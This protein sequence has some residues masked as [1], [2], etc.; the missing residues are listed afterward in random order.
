M[1]VIRWTH[2]ALAA[3]E[4]ENPDA[5]SPCRAGASAAQSGRGP[6]GAPSKGNLGGR[7]REYHRGPA[8]TRL[9]GQP[10]S[11]HAATCIMCD[12][13]R[14][15]YQGFSRVRPRARLRVKRNSTVLRPTLRV[16]ASGDFRCKIRSGSLRRKLAN[17][18]TR[19]D[20]L[21]CPWELVVGLRGTR[22]SPS[23]F[24]TS[25]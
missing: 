14:L 18:E 11:A 9:R 4:R 7:F 10:E 12:L 13:Q 2:P 20:Q 19:K 21:R 6:D 8:V 1:R 3:V 23:P 16:R 24:Q 5:G 17:I 15:R 22:S 25:L